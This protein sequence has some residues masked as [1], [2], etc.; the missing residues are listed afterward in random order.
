MVK[1]K[2]HGNMDKTLIPKGK[3]HPEQV[4]IRRSNPISRLTRTHS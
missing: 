3:D 1:Q 2:P 4:P